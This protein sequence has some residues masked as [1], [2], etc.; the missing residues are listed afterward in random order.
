MKIFTIFMALGLLF[1]PIT[2]SANHKTLVGGR[3]LIDSNDP[4]IVGP[5]DECDEVHYHGV[6]NDYPDPNPQG[7]GHGPAIAVE[8]G[9]GDGETI[10]EVSAKPSWWRTF[11]ENFVDFVADVVGAPPPFEVKRIV[12][13]VEDAAPS[14]Q[15]NI[16]NIDEY[17]E[18]VS[19]E[20]D[21]LDLY[22]APEEG[23][24]EGSLSQRFFRWFSGLMD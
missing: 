4:Q 8:H 19:E 7:C 12:E 9:D 24:E 15:E 17:R 5:D 20:E 2:S 3:V 11:F 16:N 10:P 18:S 14:I 21:T 22:R 13:T 6:L 1:M 23:L